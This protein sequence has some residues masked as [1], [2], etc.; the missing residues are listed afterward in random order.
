MTA[1]QMVAQEPNKQELLMKL[2]RLRREARTLFPDIIHQDPKSKPEKN[3]Y[4]L[5]SDYHDGAHE[6]DYV[7]PYTKSGGNLDAKVMILLQDWSSHEALTSATDENM[8][9]QIIAQ[10]RNPSRGTN[11]N[12]DVLLKNHFNISIQQTYATNLFPFVKSGDISNDIIK[13]HMVWAAKKF[14]RAQ[15]EIV[16]PKIVICCG[17]ATFNAMREAYDLP[18]ANNMTAAMGDVASS[19]RLQPPMSPFFVTHDTTTIWCQA[20]PSQQGQNMR[21]ANNIEADWQKMAQLY[22][23]LQG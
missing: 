18:S 6:G 16:K 10:G 4:N 11:K 15:I 19:E 3:F 8:F 21:G 20:H 1:E 22:R 9:R 5:I 17:L 14:A 13:K 7:S 12:L 23:W 2:V